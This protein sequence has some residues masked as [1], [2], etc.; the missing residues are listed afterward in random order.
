[1]I[2]SGRVDCLLVVLLEG[3]KWLIATGLWMCEMTVQGERPSLCV[4][5]SHTNQWLFTDG[6]WMEMCAM[7]C[8]KCLKVHLTQW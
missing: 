8:A 3:V 6:E 7:C 1:M 2:L 5:K 4:N